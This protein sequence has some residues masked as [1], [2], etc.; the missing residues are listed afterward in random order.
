MN[1]EPESA[2]VS[3]RDKKCNVQVFRTSRCYGNNLDLLTFG[4]GPMHCTARAGDMRP[5]FVDNK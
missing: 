3:S 5:L 1:G 2:G 4:V